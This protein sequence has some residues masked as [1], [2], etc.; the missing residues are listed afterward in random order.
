MEVPTN[1]V[2]LPKISTPVPPYP[3]WTWKAGIEVYLLE[4]SQNSLRGNQLSNIGG[5]GCEELKMKLQKCVKSK[6]KRKGGQTPNL[7]ALEQLKANVFLNLFNTK[8]ANSP[9]NRC[10]DLRIKTNCQNLEW[11]TSKLLTRYT[12]FCT[13]GD[14]WLDSLERQYIF[15]L[16]RTVYECFLPFGKIF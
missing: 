4:I 6:V 8:Y 14:Y 9:R 13:K 5:I 12:R 10:K 11:D 7:T 16:L 1:A 3:H 15:C 2:S